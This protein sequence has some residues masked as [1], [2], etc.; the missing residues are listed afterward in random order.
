MKGEP[1]NNLRMSIALFYTDYSDLPYQVSTTQGAGFDTRNII[2][3]QTSTGVEWESSWAITDRFLLHATV[4]YIN[5]DVDDPV[6]VAPLTPEW[7]ASI[8]PEYTMGLKNGGEVLF[9]ADWSYRD[10]MYGEPTADPGRFTAIDSRALLNFNVTYYPPDA[11]W[12]VSLYGTNVTDERYDNAR[13]NTGD[14]LLVIL[15]NDASEFGVRFTSY[16]GQ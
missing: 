14:Y 7:T 2:V 16:F 8:S 1:L 11:N 13:L 10:D 5:V 3:D 12:D 15:N 6:A 9:R 4:G